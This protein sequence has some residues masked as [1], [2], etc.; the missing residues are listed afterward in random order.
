MKKFFSYL[1]FMTVLLGGLTLSSCTKK[2]T[3]TVNSNHDEW[4]VVSGGGEYAM[5]SQVT[6]SA[7][8]KDGY[9]FLKW[10]DGDSQNPRTFTVMA[11]ATYTA[12]FV[13]LP[14][15]EGVKVSFHDEQW[16]AE[17]VHAEYNRGD[18]SWSVLA[19]PKSEEDFPGLRILM[20]KDSPGVLVASANTEGQL[21]NPNFGRIEYA[22][23]TVLEDG[24][25]RRGDY[26]A[27]V[28]TMQIYEFDP[29]KMVFTADLTAT[30]FSAV[31]AF[32]G[33]GGNDPVGVDAASTAPMKVTMTK[34][35]MM[36]H[37]GAK[38]LSHK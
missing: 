29:N 18:G 5:G 27:K 26:W 20:Y 3:I 34:V 23:E 38:R 37:A 7:K 28:V 4:G 10:D 32:V 1:V 16:E 9:A 13:E 12:I 33:V 30:M 31:E 15:E 2:Y 25:D 35:Q 11:N 14:S 24:E 22:N 21:T 19:H 36:P 8:A 6:L 17:D